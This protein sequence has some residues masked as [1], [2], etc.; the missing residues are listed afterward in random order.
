[1][2]LWN[3]IASEQDLKKKKKKQATTKKATSS[4]LPSHPFP[5]LSN[6]NKLP[7]SL[8]LRDILK[9]EEIRLLSRHQLE[10]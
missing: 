10:Y 1:M 6:V 3:Q 5:A 7:Q 2:K 8:L 4:F 9:R